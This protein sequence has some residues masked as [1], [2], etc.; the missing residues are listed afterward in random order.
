MPD[1]KIILPLLSLDDIFPEKFNV[2]SPF[3]VPKDGATVSHVSEETAVHLPL[4]VK[5]TLLLPAVFRTAK[6]D[7]E[8]VNS[9]S[10]SFLHPKVIKIEI[11]K[12]IL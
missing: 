12:N 10:G 1:V 2:H 6:F 9:G 7:C 3:P 4:H 11:I 8:R 5:E